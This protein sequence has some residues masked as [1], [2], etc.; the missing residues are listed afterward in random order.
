MLA[1]EI[2]NEWESPK[3]YWDEGVMERKLSLDTV[4]GQEPISEGTVSVAVKDTEMKN[5][6]E[7]MRHGTRKKFL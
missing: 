3:C 2:G 6:E 1:I 5:L 4:G 7:K